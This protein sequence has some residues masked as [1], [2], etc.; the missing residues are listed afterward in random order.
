MCFET[1]RRL[2]GAALLGVLL[3]L[4]AGGPLWAG[5][6]AVGRKVPPLILPPRPSARDQVVAAAARNAL[7]NRR[8]AVVAMDPHTGRVLAL[9]N[10]VYGLFYSYQPC[11]VFKIVVAMAGLAEG[12]ITPETRLTCDGGCWLWPGHGP[13]DLRR[14]LAV[15]CNPFFQQVGERLGYGQVKRYAR[16]LGLG[17]V[18]GINL[19]GETKGRLPGS[20]TP[21]RVPL[22]SSH[23]TGVRTSAVQLA[24]LMSAAVN[25]GRI[26]QPQV[27]GAEG[28]TPRERWRV[29]QHA[30]L[31]DLKAGFLGAV[32]EGS[33]RAA[34]DP[35]AVVA[36]KTGTCSRLG[37]FA[38]YAPADDPEL[39]LVVFVR[40]GSGRQA[41]TIGGRI[42]RELYP[43]S[44]PAE[45]IDVTAELSAPSSAG[46][47]LTDER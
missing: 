31:E 3:L 20:V 5:T 15:S 40:R 7:G 24:V 36:G 33:A 34:F 45:A 39:V 47:Q 9:V 43:R 29:P 27:A 22:L 4:D 17:D 25:G 10:P 19:T 2:T 38:S 41:A 37:W 26:F 13:L 42:F 14:A 21:A 16:L 1:I 30:V 18:S 8:G 11:S 6:A 12:V 46:A 28:F 35:E 23:A 44:Q 32:N